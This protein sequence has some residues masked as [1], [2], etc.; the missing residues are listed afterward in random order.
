MAGPVE[1]GSVC[2]RPGSDRPGLVERVCRKIVEV[3]S[4]LDSEDVLEGTAGG[5]CEA[6]EA[7]L[8]QRRDGRALIGTVLMLV[9]LILYGL[10]LAGI[11]AAESASKS[12]RETQSPSPSPQETGCHYVSESSDVA[13]RGEM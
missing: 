6:L 4:D 7:K 5:D 13:L 10:L 8:E 3:N 9:S 1:V 2:D 11:D 12:P